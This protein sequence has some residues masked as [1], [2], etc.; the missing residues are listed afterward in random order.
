MG[1]QPFDMVPRSTRRR[2]VQR[3]I[4]LSATGLVVPGMVIGREPV[5]DPLMIVRSR[6]P[7]DAET[8]VE[9]FE[10]QVTP[11]RLFF[12]RS[13]FGVPAVGLTER[14]TLKIDGGVKRETTF[15][16]DDLSQFKQVTIPAVLQCTGNGRAFYSPTIPGV[17]WLKGAVGNAEWT[18]V[19]LAELL[20]RAGVEPG[21]AHVHLHAADGPPMPKTPAYLRSI[22][23]DRAT[24]ES[25]IVA[26]RMNGEPLPAEHGGP[27]R[28]VVPGWSGNHWIKWLRTLVVAHDEAPGFFMQ[29]GYKM[30]IKPT[31]PGV[32]LKPSELKPVTVMNVKSL[33]ARPLD[34][35]RLKAGSNEARGV[36]WTGGEASVTR[37]EVQAGQGGVWRDAVLEGPAR[38]F[39]WRRWRLAFDANG[40]GPLVIRARATDSDGAVQPEISPWNKSGYLWNGYDHVACE[41]E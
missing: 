39:T 19:R 8:P 10:S 23:L 11:N 2:F 4:A 36:A 22:P 14:W 17:G 5:P 31:A 30:P 24:A 1:V 35:A 12:I 40:L 18:G 25:T 38:P 29:A 28:L 21:M 15:S 26:L 37:V 27:I 33:I 20:D 9:V 32:D 7:L 6:R 16:L 34:G 3:T 41:V 13:H